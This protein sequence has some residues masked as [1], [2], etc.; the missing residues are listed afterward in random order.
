MNT[1][2]TYS[3]VLT[4]WYIRQVQAEI[5]VTLEGPHGLRPYI[6][7]LVLD[8]C[9]NWE[10]QSAEYLPADS[11]CYEDVDAEHLTALDLH[12]EFLDELTVQAGR[13]LLWI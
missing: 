5:E 4:S 7:T 3:P 6:L 9:E 8:A 10:V 13:P 11:A 12:Q 2:Q 1:S